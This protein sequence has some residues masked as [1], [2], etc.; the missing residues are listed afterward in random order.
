LQNANLPKNM[1][2]K[3]EL[4]SESPLERESFEKEPQLGV[5]GFANRDRIATIRANV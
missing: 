5:G 4:D 3:E 1:R 2:G